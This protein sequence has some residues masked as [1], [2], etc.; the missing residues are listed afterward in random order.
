MP[1][2]R[3]TGVGLLVTQFAG[4]LEREEFVQ[5]LVAGG[6]QVE[7]VTVNGSPGLWLEGGPH[8]VLF[9][10]PEGGFGEDEARLAGNTLLFEAGGVLVRI[11]GEI[12]R[13]RALEIA[14]SIERR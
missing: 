5:K 3:H 12:D 13:A 9:R 7:Q 14:E 4:G 11:E 8:F 6:T 2:S 1:R 10:T